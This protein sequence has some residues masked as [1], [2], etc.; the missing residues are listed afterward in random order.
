MGYLNRRKLKNGARSPIYWC[1][2]YVDGRP[3]RESTGCEKEQDARRVLKE[4]E[5]RVAIG[6]PILPRAD[7]IRYDEGAADL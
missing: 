5:G 4:R 6:G 1:K 3:M 7:R 2:Y